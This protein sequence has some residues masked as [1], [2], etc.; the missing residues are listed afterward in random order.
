MH[1]RWG[2]ATRMCGA[3]LRTETNDV[4]G[5]LMIPALVLMVLAG[6]VGWHRAGKRG[7][8][9]ADR[10]QYA[11]AHGIPAF[12]AVLILMTIAGRMGWLG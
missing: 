3:G 2:V 8:T 1:M 4:A 10:F 9:T 12:L 11:A 7:G 6:A 5:D